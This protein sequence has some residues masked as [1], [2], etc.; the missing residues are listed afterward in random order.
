MPWVLRLVRVAWNANVSEFRTPKH[1]KNQKHSHFQN[2]PSP[3][4]PSSR[5]KA[6]SEFLSPHPQFVITPLGRKA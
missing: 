4:R 3:P 6:A 1:R 5:P 2:A